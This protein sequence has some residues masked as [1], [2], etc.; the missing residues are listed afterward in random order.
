MPEPLFTDEGVLPLY[1]DPLPLFVVTPAGLRWLDCDETDE[2]VRPGAPIGRLDELVPLLTV[3]VAGL[4][5]LPA[6]LADTLSVLVVGVVLATVVLLT[7]D[8]PDEGV[9]V[10]EA[11]LLPVLSFLLTVLLLPIP[12][13]IDEVLPNTLSDPV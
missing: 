3:P 1:E 7:A 2:G 13:L 4:V 9:L 6:G 12:P 5:T 10:T 8:L 11:V